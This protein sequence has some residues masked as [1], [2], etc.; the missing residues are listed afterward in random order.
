MTPQEQYAQSIIN[1]EMDYQRERLGEEEF[2]RRITDDPEIL[3]RFKAG[4]RQDAEELATLMLSPADYAPRIA[5]GAL[6]PSSYYVRRLFQAI[7]GI[8]LPNTVS[9]TA[10]AI[11]DS[12]YGPYV[13]EWY[14]KR[15]QERDQKEQERKEKEEREHLALVKELEDSIRSITPKTNWNRLTGL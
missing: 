10:E 14:A 7:T 8:T 3:E 11:R 2:N 1:H 15:Q 13:A 4:V 12:V 6:H 5:Q 9:G